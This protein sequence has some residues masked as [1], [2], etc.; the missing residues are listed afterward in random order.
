MGP[1]GFV[2]VIAGWVT[3]EVG[4]QPYTVY[5]QLLTAKS[6]S[7]LAAPAVAASLVVFALVYFSVFG[8]GTA[9]LLRMMVRTPASREAE[10]PHLPQRAAGITPAPGIEHVSGRER[11]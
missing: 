6:H 3:T 9:Y 4:R 7:P 5:G 2:A 11:P 8:A 10:P 1:A